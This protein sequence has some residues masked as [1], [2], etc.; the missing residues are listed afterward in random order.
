MDGTPFKSDIK[1]KAT[2]LGFFY[3]GFSKAEFLEDEAPKLEKWLNKNYNGKMAYMSNHFDLRLDPR[4]LVPGAKSVISLLFNYSTSEEQKDKDAPKISKYAFGEDYHYVVKE[5]L[6]ELFD[7]AKGIIG[8]INGRVFV[9]SAPV[10]DK[11]WAKKS[12]LGWVGKNSNLIHPREGSF[13]FIAEMIIDVDFEPDGPIKDYC[14][15]CTKCIDACPTDAIVE[16]YVVD[17]SRCISYLTIELKDEI[18]PNEFKSKMDNWAFGCDV[19]QDIC[20]WNRFTKAT[21]EKRLS[22]PKLLDLSKKEWQEMSKE[23]YDELFKRSAVKRAKYNGLKRNM[24]F[25]KTS[26]KQ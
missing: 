10:M 13:F 18:L 4:K 26:T 9:D 21:N 11:V 16:P 15:S 20:P 22:N 1:A 14:G 6:F 8:D 23:F 2:E 12:G 5:R 19:C 24:E 3:C 25:L 7:F 17:G